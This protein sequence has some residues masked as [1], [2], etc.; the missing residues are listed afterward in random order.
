MFYHSSKVQRLITPLILVVK[1]KSGVVWT[2]LLKIAD[3]LHPAFLHASWRTWNTFITWIGSM[4]RDLQSQ[5][6]TH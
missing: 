2:G 1:L 4:E 5:T 3:H 6:F